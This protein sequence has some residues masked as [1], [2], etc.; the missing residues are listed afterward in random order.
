MKLGLAGPIDFNK[1]LNKVLKVGG[2]L[3]HSLAL[4]SGGLHTPEGEGDGFVF[5]GWCQ[6]SLS[7]CC[8]VVPHR[9]LFKGTEQLELS[10]GKFIKQM[11]L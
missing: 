6:I 7:L 8:S 2:T 11:R 1:H 4:G 9:T 10:L 5:M 3:L